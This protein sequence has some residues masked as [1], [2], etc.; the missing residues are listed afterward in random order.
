MATDKIPNFLKRDK[1][2]I[3]FNGEGQFIFY[4]PEIYFER[5]CAIIIGDMVN[6][7]GILDYTILDKNGK[8]NGLHLFRF[9]TVFLTRPGEIEKIK[10]VQLTKYS[11]RQDYRLLKYNKGDEI[12]ISVRV[13]QLADNIDQFYKMFISSK[14]PTTIPYDKLYEYFPEN[15][16]LNGNDYGINL[17]LF[18]IVTS[19]LCRDPKDPKKL[20]RHTDMKDM[21]AYRFINI[22]EVPN[23]VSP[24]TAITSE[25][26]NESMIN[27]INSKDGEAKYSPMESLFVD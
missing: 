12:V 23:Y 20:F 14:L 8:N 19:E 13:P 10:D 27:A 7:I 17:Q 24:F 15:V 5:N 1:D 4:V 22:K 11:D 6:L 18:G 25:N 3:L 2:K 26:W 21:T 16:R 9:P